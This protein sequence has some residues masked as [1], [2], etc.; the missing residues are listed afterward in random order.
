[1]HM[2]G[3]AS[4]EVKTFSTWNSYSRSTLL[5]SQPLGIIMILNSDDISGCN[6]Q[7]HMVHFQNK[8]KICG[9]FWVCR[10]DSG[11]KIMSFLR[12]ELNIY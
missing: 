3:V 9:L 8:L 12:V 7:Q 10:V 2:L 1:M 5:K 11:F 6:M 4:N